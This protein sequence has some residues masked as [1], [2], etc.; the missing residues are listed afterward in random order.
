MNKLLSVL[1]LDADT[2]DYGVLASRSLCYLLMLVTI[3][4]GS[5]FLS[6]GFE[7]LVVFDC[8]YLILYGA[9]L[10]ASYNGYSHAMKE[11]IMLVSLSQ[12]ILIANIFIGKESG[13]HLFSI[14]M[15]PA[16]YVCVSRHAIWPK[17]RIGLLSVLALVYTETLHSI[18]PVYTLSVQSI[19]GLKISVIFLVCSM[20]FIFYLMFFLH[21]EES[22]RILRKM[23]EY[24]DLTGLANRRCFIQTL[25]QLDTT[26]RSHYLLLIDLD[27]FKTV[28]DTYGH[29]VGD[30]VLKHTSRMMQDSC[31]NRG[32]AA[33]LGGEEFTL[34]LTNTNRNEALNHAQKLCN[35]IQSQPTKVEQ[36]GTTILV[37]CTVS[38]GVKKLSADIN[39]TLN[40]ADKAMYQAKNNGRNQ[41]IMT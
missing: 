1:Q 19:T 27:Y 35:L 17:I 3:G 26:T 8:G 29:Q 21:I 34:C 11:T 37:K 28:N 24:D 7:Y 13:M 33:R 16:T 23:S 6:L 39:Q 38:I 41:A 30:E 2:E 12:I 5:Y 25:Q 32:T 40:A 14:G 22:N 4:Y 18:D 9:C 36:D 15:I 31:E 20:V 10:L